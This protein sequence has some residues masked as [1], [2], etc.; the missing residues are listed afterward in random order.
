MGLTRRRSR[1]GRRGGASRGCS[2]AVDLPRVALEAAEQDALEVVRRHEGVDRRRHPLRVVGPTITGVTMMTSSVWPRL[3]PCE[4]NSAPSTGIVPSAGIREVPCDELFCISPAMAKLWPLARST[5]VS[6]RRVLQR[7]H[8]GAVGEVELA[9]L[10]RDLQAD[11]V[12]VEH[13]R[14]E[15]QP[16][17][18]VLELDVGAVVADGRVGVLAAGQEVRRLA[19]A[20]G[21]VRLGQDRDQPLLRQRLQHHVDVEVAAGRAV[22]TP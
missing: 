14:G 1:T 10:G 3:K 18:E 19:G 20:R 17:A 6:A 8:V 11:P 9:D 13:R 5:V 22:A 21:Q 16:D 4:R 7:R 15:V 12:A 2:H